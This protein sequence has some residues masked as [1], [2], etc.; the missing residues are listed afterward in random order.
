[1]SDKLKVLVVDDNEDLLAT[2]S[3]I[4]RGYGFSVTTAY[5]GESAVDTFRLED[6]DVILMDVVMPHMNGVEAFRAIRDIDPEAAVI[7][8]TAYSEEELI[9]QALAGGVDRVVYKPVSVERV[10]EMVWDAC[11]GQ[12]VLIV[13]DDA[14][15]LDTLARTLETAGHR[16]VTAASGEEAVRIVRENACPIAFVDIKLPL[17]DGLE[18]YLRLKEI[19][20]ATTAVMMTGFRNEV[21]DALEKAQAAAA[22]ACLFKPFD[23]EKAVE[24]VNQ[25]KGAVGTVSSYED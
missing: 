15:L 5:D 1:M 22:I 14:D 24:M 16:A 9:Q 8:M 11:M 7:L 20:P 21:R 19:N 3:L 4:L 18:T 13:D 6:F 23:P 2:L 25:I 10:I 17:M 12:P